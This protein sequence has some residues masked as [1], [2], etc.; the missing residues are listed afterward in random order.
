MVRGR[1]QGVHRRGQGGR[2]VTSFVTLVYGDDVLRVKMGAL[3][4]PMIWAGGTTDGGEVRIDPRYIV[5]AEERR[6]A[7]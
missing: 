7:E 2:A 1:P 5:M 4:G 3:D 6:G